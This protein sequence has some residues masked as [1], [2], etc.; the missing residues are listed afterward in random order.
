MFKYYNNESYFLD[1][2]KNKRLYFASFRQFNDP[3][4]IFGFLKN[5]DDG[6]SYVDKKLKIK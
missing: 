1:V 2:L 4:E 5:T 6:K 3:Y